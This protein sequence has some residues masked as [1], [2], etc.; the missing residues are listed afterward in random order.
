MENMTDI[1][2]AF[3][4]ASYPQAYGMNGSFNRLLARGMLLYVGGLMIAEAGP[5]L[6]GLLKKFSESGMLVRRM[7]L[8]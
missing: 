4:P 8:R 2:P 7:R 5:N 1:P 6:L 3:S